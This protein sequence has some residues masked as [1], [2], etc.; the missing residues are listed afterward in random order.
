[1]RAPVLALC[2]LALVGC[3]SGGGGAAVSRAEL[4]SSVLQPADLGAGWARFD[5]GRQVRADAHPG[6]RSDAQRFDR[7]E[8]WKARYHR[9][10]GSLGKPSV[11]ESRA[12]LFQGSA[13]AGKDLDAYRKELAAGIP[14][15][16]AEVGLLKA[17]QLGDEAV[18]AKLRQGPLVLFTVAWRRSNATAS[19]LVEGRSGVTTV[20]DA[21][22]LASKQDRRLERA[23]GA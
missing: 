10:S 21:L 19:V 6:P 9:V 1:V 16:G 2:V 5:A 20:Q 13:G 4:P 8:G 3:S 22:A 18:A 11:V 7:I 15:S 14:G 17:P 12:D 23:A